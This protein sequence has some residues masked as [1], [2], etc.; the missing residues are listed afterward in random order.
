MWGHCENV[1]VFICFP[2]EVV[3]VQLLLTELEVHFCLE[4]VENPVKVVAPAECHMDVLIFL[5]Q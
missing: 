1:V 3:V 4:L 2:V 5:F